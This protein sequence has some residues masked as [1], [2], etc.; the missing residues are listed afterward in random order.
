MT[1]GSKKT[2]IRPIALLSLVGLIGLSG[3]QQTYDD[4]KGWGNDVEAWF[5]DD[6]IR[7]VEASI[8]IIEEEIA[9]PGETMVAQEPESQEPEGQDPASDSAE[10][11]AMSE[12]EVMMPKGTTAEGKM[13]QPEMTKPE[14]AKA[15]MAETETTPPSASPERSANQEAQETQVA[16]TAPEVPVMAAKKAA[17][18][19]K[20]RAP[21]GSQNAQQNLYPQTAGKPAP[22]PAAEAK[23]S[24]PQKA[25]GK[26]AGMA[27]HL[28]S[29]RTKESASREW[30][31]LKTAFPEQ[32]G[33]LD[34]KIARTDLGE[35]G[36]F[37]RVMAGS[38]TD[39]SS[40]SRICAE[41][42]KKKQYCAV[43]RAP[44]AA[45]QAQTAEKKTAG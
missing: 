15:E 43:M 41:L 36:V 20:S 29:N 7:H 2:G 17:M 1:F 9:G 35:K 21:V 11:A 25:A 12:G 3:C 39:K 24:K 40:A 14:M 10:A 6:F 38:F 30:T 16:S 44:K 4:T 37:F 31:Q 34:L 42:R 26:P 19:K 18:E 5:R 27:L 45:S 22:E 33:N 13:A 32:L 8:E 23:A 28:S